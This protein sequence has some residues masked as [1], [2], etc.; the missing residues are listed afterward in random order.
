L[1]VNAESID[2]I[3]GQVNSAAT[4]KTGN[5]CCVFLVPGI[6]AALL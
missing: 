6:T 1:N 2:E 5:P 3:S 4:G